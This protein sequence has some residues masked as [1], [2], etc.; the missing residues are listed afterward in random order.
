MDR[1]P[2]VVGRLNA[3]EAIV[4]ELVIE[5]RKR[6]VN[7]LHEN[8]QMLARLGG[9]FSRMREGEW[10]MACQEGGESTIRRVIEACKLREAPD[11]GEVS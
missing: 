8:D 10:N 6:G 9:Q 1:N 3:L 4:I 11:S 7:A 5:E 2:E